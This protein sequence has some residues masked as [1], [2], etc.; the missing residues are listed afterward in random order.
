MQS[1]QGRRAAR[2][3]RGIASAQAGQILLAT[4]FLLLLTAAFLMFVVN[5]GQSV[6]EKTRLNNAADAAAYSAAVIEARAL[7][8]DAHLNR[9]MVANE[10]VIAQ[11]VS[12]ASWLRYVARGID[13][14]P[15]TATELI[16]Y[17]AP[18]PDAMKL[19][20]MFGAAKFLLEYFTGQSANDY[21]DYVLEFGVGFGITA[22]DVLIKAMET[23]QSLVHANLAGGIRQWM[24]ADDIVR[25]MDPDMRAQVVLTS[26]GFDG[27][28]KRW[29]KDGDT[30]DER[31]RFADVTMRS[32]DE[33]TR[34]RNWTINGP[35]LLVPIPRRD[36]ALKKRAGTDLVGYD[37]WRAVDTLELHGEFFDCKGGGIFGGFFKKWCG[38]VQRSIGWAGVNINAGGGDAGHAY[39]GNAYSEN[40]R[41]ADKADDDMEEPGMYSFHGLPGVRELKD[42]DPKAEMKTG[43]TI[44]VSKAHD[45][46]LTSGGKATVKP[47]GRLARFDDKPSGKKMISLARGEVYFD[48]IARRADGKTELASL[49]NPYWR[50]R[51]VTP[52]DGDKAYAAAQQ[53]GMTYLVTP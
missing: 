8:Y 15:A 44:L 43:I 27:F 23:S 16:L 34:E 35:D 28:T 19:T 37:E 13:E 12:V 24:V 50:A 30:G 14:V 6:V 3:R 33:F 41:T 7:N 38:D 9:A 17:L 10:I 32:R 42:V 20:A 31:G 47:G 52:T 25:A 36:A 40:R 29:A 46:L 22:H 45:K 48:R 11:H 53:E 2:R 26:H 51:L 5:T 18:D 39:H 21:A 4:V 1:I 49:Y